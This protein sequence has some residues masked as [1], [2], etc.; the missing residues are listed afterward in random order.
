M[1]S[2]SSAHKQAVACTMIFSSITDG[3]PLLSSFTVMPLT[4][5]HYQQPMAKFGE[6]LFLIL[7]IT[8]GKG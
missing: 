4:N 8:G 5:E 1:P 3:S 2:C 7:F 6:M